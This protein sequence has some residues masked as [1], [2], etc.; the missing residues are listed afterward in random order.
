MRDQRVT[1]LDPI[2]IHADEP[3][4]G[5]IFAAVS[6]WGLG[7][8]RRRVLEGDLKRVDRKKD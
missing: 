5:R 7:R 8:D 6:A 2:I 4:Y 1:I 3:S